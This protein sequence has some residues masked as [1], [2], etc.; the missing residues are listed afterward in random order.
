MPDLYA[1]PKHLAVLKQCTSVVR[2]DNFENRVYGSCTLDS[3][4][5]NACDFR[6][7]DVV[8]TCVYCCMYM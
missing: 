3:G 8:T 2:S 6:R 1:N 7:P 4:V 5:L